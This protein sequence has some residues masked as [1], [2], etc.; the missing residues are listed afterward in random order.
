MTVRPTLIFSHANGFPGGSYRTFLEPFSAHF[1]LEVVDRIGHTPQFPVDQ[2]WIGPSRELEAL[3][4]PLPKPLVGMGHSLGGVLTFMVAHRRPEWFSALVMLDPPLVNGW[5]GALFNLGRRLGMID[6]VSPAGRSLG[7]R[8]HWPDWAEV[9][10]YFNRRPFFQRLDPRCLADYL[11]AG[12]EE[13]ADGWH[14]RYAPATEVDIFRTTP[15]DIG[16]LAP[17]RGVPG[18]VV[19][20]ASSEP[21]FRQCALRHVRRHGMVH[22][23]APGG[24]MFPLEQPAA[25]SAIILEALLPMLEGATDA[26]F[27]GTAG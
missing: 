27:G 9:E 13:G 14:L 16:R 18:L 3:M 10:G 6:R 11:D 22:R 17:L 26:N 21:A 8:A 5:Q 19:S 24:H 23:M 7:R 2:G 1:E 15:G 4:E 20:G 12:L 25:A